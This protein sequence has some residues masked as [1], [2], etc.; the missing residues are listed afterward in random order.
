M[1]EQ[2]LNPEKPT[3]ERAIEDGIREQECSSA[4][5]QYEICSRF[6]RMTSEKLYQREL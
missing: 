3:R 2:F 4:D 5:L 6:M 1:F